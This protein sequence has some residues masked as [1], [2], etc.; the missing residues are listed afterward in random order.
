MLDSSMTTFLH[1]RRLIKPQTADLQ[2]LLTFPDS[3]QN[4]IGPRA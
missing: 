4:I 1:G 3:H 2:A